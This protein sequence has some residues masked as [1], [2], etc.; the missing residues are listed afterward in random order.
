MIEG[1][2]ESSSVFCT[3]SANIKRTIPKAI[4]K[5]IQQFITQFGSSTS[6]II[7][8]ANTNNA[9]NI[10]LNGLLFAS[11]AAIKFLLVPH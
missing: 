9:I 11:G 4:F 5:Q 6:K 8:N 2:E 1:K 3:Y 7:S 10:S